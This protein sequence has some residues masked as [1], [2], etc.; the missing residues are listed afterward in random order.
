MVKST[1]VTPTDARMKKLLSKQ[2]NNVMESPVPQQISNAVD[3]VSIKTGVITKFYPYLDKAE[4]RLDFSNELLLCRILHRYGGDIIDFY[5]PLA[6]ERIFCEKLKEP[7]DE[8]DGRGRS[9]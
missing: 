5:T 8:R 6:D 4:V 7:A 1:E 9:N 3:N 2:I